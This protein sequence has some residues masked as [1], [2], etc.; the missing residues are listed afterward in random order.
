[1]GDCIR[2]ICMFITEQSKNGKSN[3]VKRIKVKIRYGLDNY[4]VAIG[5]Y[6]I[7]HNV[8][9]FCQIIIDIKLSLLISTNI[10]INMV[11]ALNG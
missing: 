3:K 4:S 2:K 10:T 7:F 5:R 11:N 8:D 1:M 6:C 9:I